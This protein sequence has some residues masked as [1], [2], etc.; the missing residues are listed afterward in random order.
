MR[1]KI[2]TN[3]NNARKYVYSTKI[4][5]RDIDQH[6]STAKVVPRFFRCYQKL[7]DKMYYLFENFKPNIGVS[8]VS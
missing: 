2:N 3:D 6:N 8:I 7:K 1:P 5:S 4:V